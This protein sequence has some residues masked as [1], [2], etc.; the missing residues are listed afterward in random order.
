MKNKVQEG[1]TLDHTAA[2][3][4][5]SG[6]VV[7][8][9]VRIGIAVADIKNGETGSLDVEDVYELPK[10]SADTFAQGALCYWDNVAKN[11]TTTSASNTLAGYAAAPAGA[12]TTVINVKING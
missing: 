5:L 10:K 3:D 7:V 2:A 6:D 8:I 1:K 4:I 11:I 12:S 9:G